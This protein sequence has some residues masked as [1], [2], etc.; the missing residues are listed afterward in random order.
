MLNIF[1]N[2][3]PTGSRYFRIVEK[4]RRQAL[5]VWLFV[6]LLAGSTLLLAGLQYRW[7]KEVA[8]SEQERRQRRLEADI[9]RLAREFDEEI[10]SIGSALVPRG[11]D[12]DISDQNDAA[13]E[14]NYLKLFESWKESAKNDH[15]VKRLVR[16]IPKG[17]TVLLRQMDPT[18]KTFYPTDW[19]YG[20]ESFKARLTARLQN[21]E[22]RPRPMDT[23]TISVLEFPRW[24]RRDRTE[25]A[26][27]RERE[28]VAIE[29][30]TTV[31]QQEM[32]PEL[33]Q[34]HLGG[35]GPME[36]ESEIAM[37]ETPDVFVYSSHPS[38]PPIAASADAYTTLFRNQLRRGG[39][40]GGGGGERFGGPRAGGRNPDQGRW[41]LS[42][43][44]K[45]GSLE[46]A[47]SRAK[48][49]NI[50]LTT[51]ILALMLT[52][53]GALLWLTRRAQQLAYMQMEFVASISHEL[54]TPLAV[55][56]TAAFNLGGGIVKF[57]NQA[58]VERYANL[59]K[60]QV[61]KLGSIV[62]NVLRFAGTRSGQTQ[63][64]QEPLPVDQ[65]ID[66]ALSAS[67]QVIAESGCTIERN[68]SQEMLGIL[69]DETG[70]QQV[71]QNLISNAAKYGAAGGWIG[72][73]ASAC[74]NGGKG[75]VEIKVADRGAGIPKREASH[76]FE[77]FFR[78]KKAV[79]NQIHGTGL[80]LS[81]TK[82]I[83]EGQGGTIAVRSE[84]GK[85]TEFV[86]RLTAASKEAMNEFTNFVG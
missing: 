75:K 64:K 84:E 3:P 16:V 74:D 71:L 11:F 52:T 61:S 55:I 28:W 31:L 8:S 14:S 70:L 21:E 79:E 47:V 1:Y 15:L 2:N 69:G 51:G 39:P 50:A 35:A 10:S 60:D 7:I 86:V 65:L 36:Y 67:A 41:L 27:I 57:Q 54:R 72:I 6:G 66:E 48:T 26:S 83:V 85:G 20:W 73:S 37:R 81:L 13:I 63:W 17:E 33:V 25:G 42:V 58:Q 59:I 78:G 49:R 12:A 19:P 82:R 56:N 80:G 5:F 22:S 24:N 77:P 38:S 30:D 40:R 53:I 4:N 32:L 23:G 29:L 76:I 34:R 46:A 9:D 68:V 43:R 62:E 45:E 18:H 44:H